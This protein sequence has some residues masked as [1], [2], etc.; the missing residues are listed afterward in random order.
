VF[1]LVGLVLAIL[2]PI[3]AAV[4][5]AAISRRREQLA[6]LSGVQLTRY[7]PGLIGALKKLQADRTVVRTSSRATAAMWVESPL[8]RGDGVAG[9]WN[10]LFDTHPPLE[11]RIKILEEL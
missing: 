6:D 11:E 9:R 8:Q 4:M 7:P 5:Q 3:V 2:M 1:F 10:R